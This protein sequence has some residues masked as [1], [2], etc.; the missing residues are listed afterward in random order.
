MYDFFLTLLNEDEE[1]NQT[2]KF[3]YSIAVSVL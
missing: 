3:E 1:E 2:A